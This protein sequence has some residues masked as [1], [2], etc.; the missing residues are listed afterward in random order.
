MGLHATPLQL[1]YFLFDYLFSHVVRLFQPLSERHDEENVQGKVV[2][3][4]GANSGLGKYTAKSMAQRGATVIMGCRNM[5]TGKQAQ[6]E[7]KMASGG[8]AARVVSFFY[9]HVK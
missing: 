1:I 8:D 5:D 6:Q 3:V 7:I 4:T 9:Q 2:V